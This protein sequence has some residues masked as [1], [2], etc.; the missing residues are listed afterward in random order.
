VELLSRVNHV[1]LVKLVG[2]CQEARYRVLVY[3]HAEEG[4]LW[5]H[6]HGEWLLSYRGSKPLN[7]HCIGFWDVFLGFC[8][9]KIPYMLIYATPNAGNGSS[10]DWRTR[11]KVSLESAC[12][13]LLETALDISISF[14]GVN[15]E[16]VDIG[17]QQHE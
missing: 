9:L 6:I 2:Y 8:E 14:V 16:L 13:M 10:L 5:D 7:F 3:E 12:G 4:T 1:N 15:C 17:S 11:L